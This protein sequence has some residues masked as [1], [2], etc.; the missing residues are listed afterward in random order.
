[1]E[2]SWVL[3]T[4]D[5]SC[6]AWTESLCFLSGRECRCER[7]INLYLVQA[8]FFGDYSLLCTCYSL[9]TLVPS[10]SA[11]IPMGSSSSK[12]FFS[13][14]QKNRCHICPQRTREKGKKSTG[15]T[16]QQDLELLIRDL[17]EVAFPH[18]TQPLLIIFLLQLTKPLNGMVHS[19][20][21]FFL[22]DQ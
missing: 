21:L 15:P 18:N 14:L 9:T 2:R 20:S 1:M 3:I 16:W 22:T 5:L 17:K 13:K 11:V 8:V 19:I 10:T 4:T 12:S 7:Q 6:Q